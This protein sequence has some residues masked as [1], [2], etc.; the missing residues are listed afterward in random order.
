MSVHEAR[1]SVYGHT[2]MCTQDLC[3]TLTSGSRQGLQANSHS[4]GAGPVG[5]CLW[6]FQEAEQGLYGW[7]WGG[8]LL[9]FRQSSGKTGL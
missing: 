9:H 6:V 5:V 4:G 3:V 7:G 2:H 8:A 1:R